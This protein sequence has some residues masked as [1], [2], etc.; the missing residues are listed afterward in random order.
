MRNEY[1][2]TLL[3][4]FIWWECKFLEVDIKCDVWIW[5]VSDG[6]VVWLWGLVTREGDDNGAGSA[7]D[8]VTLDATETHLLL[9]VPLNGLHLS[10]SK[11]FMAFYSI[12]GNFS[13]T[14][15][16]NV[17]NNYGMVFIKAF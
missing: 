5:C 4:K 6:A 16:V 8:K 17:P 2:I 15:L 1:H 9:I 13:D 14:N 3:Q 12:K 10:M 7:G 11:K